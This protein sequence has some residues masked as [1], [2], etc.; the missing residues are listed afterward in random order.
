MCLL[1]L[2]I[3]SACENRACRWGGGLPGTGEGHLTSHLLVFAPMAKWPRNGDRVDQAWDRKWEVHAREPPH[4]ARAMD[5]DPLVPRERGVPLQLLDVAGPLWVRPHDLVAI[6]RPGHRDRWPLPTVGSQSPGSP[7]QNG[8]LPLSAKQRLP[9]SS[10]EVRQRDARAAPGRL[11]DTLQK[12]LAF[13]P[14]PAY[15]LST[16][17]PPS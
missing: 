17:F 1:L 10:P 11:A 6:K 8:F 16:H 14:A 7:Q 4:P 12:S 13:P 3:L 15:G 2:V 9:R 5:T